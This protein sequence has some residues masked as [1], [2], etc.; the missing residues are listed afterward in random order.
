MSGNNGPV[1][2]AFANAREGAVLLDTGFQEVRCREVA[3]E[4]L[5]P[6]SRRWTGGVGEK[7][8]ES[9]SFREERGSQ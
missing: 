6:D 9:A 2:L 1:G 5:A 8:L 4:R 3:P 7:V